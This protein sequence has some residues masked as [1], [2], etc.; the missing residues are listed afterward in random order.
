MLEYNI[1]VMKCVEHYF[2]KVKIQKHAWKYTLERK[3]THGSVCRS[4]FSLSSNCKNMYRRKRNLF[5]EVCSWVALSGFDTK[6]RCWSEA[7][8]C[9]YVQ[10]IFVRFQSTQLNILERNCT[11]VNCGVN[12]IFYRDSIYKYT[13]KHTSEKPDNCEFSRTV[14][15]VSSH[16]KG[17]MW[18]HSG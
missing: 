14:Y 13:C 17:H 15:L 16:L 7:L 4:A 18:T 2:N 12:Q 1:L 3:H 5:C 8:Y 11:F 10:I 6:N 9:W